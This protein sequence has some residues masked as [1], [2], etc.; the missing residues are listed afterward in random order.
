MFLVCLRLG[1]CKPPAVLKAL[2]C[3]LQ[4]EQQRQQQQQQTI[5]FPTKNA[6]AVKSGTDFQLPEGN[7]WRYSEFINAVQSGKVE[8]VR[9]SKD[10][11]LLQVP[12]SRLPLISLS[13]LES[14]LPAERC[15]L[16]IAEAHS[17]VCPCS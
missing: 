14:L 12:V 6:P 9:F 7:Q 3:C 8:R 15:C 17:L 11:S 5:E 4:A 16:P 10:G 13:R 2:P 1:M